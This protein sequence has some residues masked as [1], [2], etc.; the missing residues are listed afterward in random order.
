MLFHEV[1]IV[2]DEIGNNF[3]Q[4]FVIIT[5]RIKEMLLFRLLLKLS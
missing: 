2:D 5:C 4:D 1:A 3:F